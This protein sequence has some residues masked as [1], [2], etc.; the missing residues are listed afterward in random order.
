[1]GRAVIERGPMPGGVDFALVLVVFVVST[2]LY[3]VDRRAGLN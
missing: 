2:M 1:M 3:F